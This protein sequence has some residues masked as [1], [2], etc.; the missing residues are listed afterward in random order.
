MKTLSLLRH[1]KSSWD[2]T[3]ERDFDR[4]VNEKGL[5][6]ATRIGEWLRQQALHFDHVLASPARRVQQTIAGIEQGYGA[7]IP[8]IAEQR[9]YLASAATLFSLIRA[10]PDQYDHLLLIGHNPGIEDLLLLA[11]EGDSSKLRREA[12][13]K[14]PTASYAQLALP[15]AHW[16]E[17]EEGLPGRLRFFV[18]PRDLDPALGPDME[19]DTGAHA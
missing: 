10:T 12:E 5:R 17:V 4:P 1:A 8:A 14:Y 11:S 19:P 3:V 13:A 7:A 2:D 18:R 9:I 15:V 6:A 16:S